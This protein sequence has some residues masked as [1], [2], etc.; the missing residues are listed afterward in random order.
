MKRRSNEYKRVSLTTP[1]SFFASELEGTAKRM[2]AALIAAGFEV[3]WGFCEDNKAEVIL[4]GL[5]DPFKV[6]RA[7]EEAGIDSI[8]VEA[9]FRFCDGADPHVKLSTRVFRYYGAFGHE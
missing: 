7:L 1:P 3:I 5:C 8:Q 4:G 2:A 9:R 6:Q